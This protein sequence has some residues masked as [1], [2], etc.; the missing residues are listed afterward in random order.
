MAKQLIR[1]TEGDLHKIIEES[2]NR[3]LKEEFQINLNN[4]GK[5]GF[6]NVNRW[7]SAAQEI[8]TK[9]STIINIP[10]DYD[11]FLQ[12]NLMKTQ[13]GGIYLETKDLK[14]EYASISDAFKALQDYAQSMVNYE[15]D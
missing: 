11:N 9:G 3:I 13:R 6:N 8:Q 2:V 7:R 4:N 15:E 1:I 12:A 14:K 5:E 10:L